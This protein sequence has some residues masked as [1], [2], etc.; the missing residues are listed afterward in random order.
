MTCRCRSPQ[1]HAQRASERADDAAQADANLML[2]KSEARAKE[3]SE[4]SPNPDDFKIIDYEQVAQHLVL[5]VRYP[6]CK[7]CSYD[8]DKVMVFFNVTMKKA[9]AW[10]RIDPHFREDKR[11]G[12]EAPS[13]AARFPASSEGWA[14]A[15]EY[16]HNKALP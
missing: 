7:R 1:E 6:G 14:D 13:P 16:A 8:G 5:K 2:R 10:T 12:L 15:V 4:R 9:L 3:L 11:E